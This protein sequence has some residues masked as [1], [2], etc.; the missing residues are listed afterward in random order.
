MGIAKQNRDGNVALELV[1]GLLFHPK[2]SNRVEIPIVWPINFLTEMRRLELK[3]RLSLKAIG[4]LFCHY[5]FYY[6]FFSSSQWCG[7]I[8]V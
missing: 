5:F 7:R 6:L 2:Y 1:G 4:N 3:L 8:G